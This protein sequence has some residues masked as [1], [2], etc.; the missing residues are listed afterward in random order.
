MM[1]HF[2]N[3]MDQLFGRSFTAGFFL[4]SPE[5][6]QT[7]MIGQ[8]GE[9]VMEGDQISAGQRQQLLL[10]VKGKFLQLQL[11]PVQKPPPRN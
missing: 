9:A 10:A 1:L 6:M 11:Q 4:N 8:I 2:F 7:E 3:Q 5:D